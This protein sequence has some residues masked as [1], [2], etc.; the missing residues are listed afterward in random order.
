MITKNS[1]ITMGLTFDDVL[2]IPRKTSATSRG[3]V[4]ISN[5][6][7]PRIRVHL[8]IVSANT[9]W[10]TESALA[11]AMARNGGIGFIHRMCLPEHQAEQVRLTKAA[12]CS[13]SEFPLASKDKDGRLLVGAAIGVRDDY[14]ARAELLVRSGADILVIDIAHGHADYALETI[15]L[16]KSRYP[17]VEIVA[18]NIATGEAARDLINAGADVLKVGVGPGSVC[19]TRIVT[20]AGVPQLTA[21]LDCVDVA[22]PHRIPVIAD[23]GIRSS[24]DMAKALAA[25]ASTVMLGSLLA[26]TDESVAALMEVDGVKYKVSTGFVTLGVK[27]TLKRLENQ[28]VTKEEFNRYTPEGIEAT[29]RYSGTAADTLAQYAGGIRSSYSYSGAT[30][31]AEFLEKAAFMQVSPAGFAEGKPHAQTSSKQVHPDY[32]K[33]LVD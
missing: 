17:N 7:S 27:L 25:G 30:N 24:G 26:G 31:T 10:C 8:P 21:I 16:I 13:A 18:G 15:S 2:L 4:D 5:Q 23:G 20:G 3:I 12:A 32:S 1:P 11:I 29:F 33:L 6:L 19:T 28:K 14:L 22:R 9:P